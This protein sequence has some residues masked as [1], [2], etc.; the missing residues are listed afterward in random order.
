VLRKA[1]KDAKIEPRRAAG[2]ERAS[3]RADY[4]DARTRSVRQG[5]EAVMKFMAI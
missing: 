5:R 3:D 4:R 1:L 2:C